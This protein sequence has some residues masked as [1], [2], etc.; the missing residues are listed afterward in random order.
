MLSEPS[1]L[2]NAMV[3]ILVQSYQAQPRWF[4]QR[5]ALP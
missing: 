4:N 5:S 1:E 3:K 2:K